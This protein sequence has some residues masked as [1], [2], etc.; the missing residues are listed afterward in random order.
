MNEVFFYKTKQKQYTK[1][2]LAASPFSKNINGRS[3]IGVNM[4]TKNLQFRRIGHFSYNPQAILS[5]W[6]LNVSIFKFPYHLKTTKPR[7]QFNSTFT[8]ECGKNSPEY[9]LLCSTIL[10]QYY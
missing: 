2:T 6:F 1:L 7:F 4:R 3:R 9:D 10:L 8:S 5:S